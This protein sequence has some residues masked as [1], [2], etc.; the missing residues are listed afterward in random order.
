MA[1]PVTATEPTRQEL[2]ARIVQLSSELEAAKSAGPPRHP[3]RATIS[4]VLLV[5]ASLGVVASTLS[6]W[7]HET[8]FDTDR[9]MAVVE[10][11]LRDPA[12]ERALATRLGDQVVTALDPETRVADALDRDPGESGQRD[13]PGRG[14]GWSGA[15]RHRTAVVGGARQ[16]GREHRRRRRGGTSQRHRCDSRLRSIREPA[17]RGDRK[18]TTASRRSTPWRLR[19]APQHRCRRGQS[20]DQP[21]ATDSRGAAERGPARAG[22]ARDRLRPSRRSTLARSTGLRSRNSRPHSASSYLRTS[23]RS[24]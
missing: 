8:L 5:L 12:V 10:P 22:P 18:G 20:H 3:V 6:F 23:V 9:F 17:G 2:E 24:R 15:N 16:P 11:V 14:S 13:Q 19:P 7:V 4:W 1:V 21:A